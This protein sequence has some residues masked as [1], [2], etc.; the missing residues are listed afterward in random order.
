LERILK[1]TVRPPAF[2]VGNVIPVNLARSE[3]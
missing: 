2:V 3:Q 1:T